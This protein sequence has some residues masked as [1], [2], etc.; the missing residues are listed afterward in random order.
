M[1]EFGH[2]SIVTGRAFVECKFI[3]GQ[4]NLALLVN[5]EHPSAHLSGGAIRA[6]VDAAIFAKWSI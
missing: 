5:H 3:A 4:I 1:L 2:A 6:V